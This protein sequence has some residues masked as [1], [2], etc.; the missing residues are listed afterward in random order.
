MQ[1][2]FEY[3][4]NILTLDNV[5]LRATNKE[6][7]M[8]LSQ[9]WNDYSIKMG[10]RSFLI[11]TPEYL[12]LEQFENWSK[13]QSTNGFAFSI[14][15]QNNQLVG[16]VSAWGMTSPILCATIG[17]FVGPNFQG[18]GYGYNAL[19]ITLNLLFNELNAHKVEIRVYNYNTNAIK[20]YEKLGFVKEG[21]IRHSSYHAGQFFDTIVYGMLKN[22]YC[23]LSKNN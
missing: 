23:E 13:N 7:L 1:E 8:Q 17:I 15:N 19:K 14:V 6:D 5:K 2:L 12:L 11:D 3:S 20:L 22:E 21:I 4:K 16:H 18:Q 10:N 9:W